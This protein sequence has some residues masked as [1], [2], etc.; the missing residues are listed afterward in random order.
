[1]ATTQIL[2][3]SSNSNLFKELA[4]T[5]NNEEDNEALQYIA[6]IML[7]EDTIN[8]L[9][10]KITKQEKQIS[11][12]ETENSHLQEKI[13]ELVNCSK[14]MDRMYSDLDR[15]NKRQK[16]ELKRLKK[17]AKKYESKEEWFKIELCFKKCI[18]SMYCKEI[19]S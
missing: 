6:K 2:R 17:K 1:M 12:S 4:T 8:K 15:D 14:A 11:K 19:E 16:T 18:S 7:L 10:K 13:V 5:D 9:G 3:N